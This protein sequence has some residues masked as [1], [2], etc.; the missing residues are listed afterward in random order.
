MTSNFRIDVL[1]ASGNIVSGSTGSL[2]NISKITTSQKLDK[3]GTLSFTIYA[4]DP[5]ASLIVPGRQFDVYTE[6]D[7]YLGRYLYSSAS[8]NDT[9][10]R[11]TI[12]VKCWD[13][14]KE[15]TNQVV[16][17]A[18][19]YSAQSIESI[20]ADLLGDVSPSWTLDI[21]TGLGTSSVTYQGQTY[22]QAIEELAKRWGYH[23]RLTSTLRELEFGAFGTLNTAVRLTNLGGQDGSFDERNDVAI[24]KRVSYHTNTDEI[25]NRI[26]AVGSGVGA[27]QLVLNDGESG[28]TYTV[29]SRAG[30][31]SQQEFY[32]EDATSISQYGVRESVVIF[33]QVRPIANTA[34]AKTQAQ[35]ELLFNAERYLERYKDVREQLNGVEVYGLR[36]PL[37]VGEKINIRYKGLDDDG[38]LALDIDDDYW[39]TEIKTARDANGMR[40]SSLQ[41]VNVDRPEKTDVDLMADVVKGIKSDRL[42]IKPSVYQTSFTYYDTIQATN[43]YPA[44]LA[45]F[46]LRI[47]DTITDITRVVIA[48]R[49]LPLYTLLQSRYED[50]ITNTPDSATYSIHRHAVSDQNLTSW[51]NVTVDNDYPAYVN[52]LIDGVNLNNNAQIDYLSGGN[53]QW[54][55]AGQNVALDVVM[56]ITDYI[57]AQ[58]SIYK[59][60]ELQFSCGSRFGNALTPFSWIGSGGVGSR[61]TSHG[62]VELTASI[63]GVAQALYKD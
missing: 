26:I 15:L 32:I 23:F 36:T 56:D 14:L 58:P 48:F 63:Q 35:T 62:I 3:I 41:I 25:Y 6:T 45:R 29:Q 49:T 61:Q 44:K 31:G 22:Y 39:I 12:T 17:F 38:N 34:T 27:A 28:D 7:G 2:R 10:G 20:I 52:F 42:W 57:L 43:P 1:D 19:N 5:K 60:F 47:D 37:N 53:G 24:V 46:V 55:S 59:D 54:N 9:D 13:L 51:F 40:V 4:N 18:R 8:K 16:G 11:A 30:G 33:D 50:G 21:G